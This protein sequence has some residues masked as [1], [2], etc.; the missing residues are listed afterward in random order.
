MLYH[1]KNFFF[2]Y[3]KTEF[4][5][6]TA[7]GYEVQQNL[8]KANDNLSMYHDAESETYMH[9]HHSG[10]QNNTN[11]I[12]SKSEQLHKGYSGTEP[13]TNNY[14]IQLEQQQ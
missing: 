8:G 6:Y 11:I 3:R 10:A 12:Q 9:T 5:E 1:F 13:H 14:Q 4:K 2:F 7:L